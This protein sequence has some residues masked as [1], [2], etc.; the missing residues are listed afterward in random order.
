MLFIFS[1]KLTCLTMNTPDTNPPESGSSALPRPQTEEATAKARIL[2]EFERQASTSGPKGVSMAEL[3]RSLG[4]ST[5]TLYRHFSNKVEL[6]TALMES[7]EQTWSRRQ[8]DNIKHARPP[9][10]RIRDSALRWMEHTSQFS[11]LFWLQIEKDFPEAHRLYQEGHTN[12]LERARQ[13][14]TPYIRDDLEPTLALAGLMALI[15]QASDNTL[16][17]HLNI[18]R[19][20]AVTQSVHL[21][22]SGALK[23]PPSNKD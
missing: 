7:W 20:D 6:V 22:A 16:C 23:T 10:E 14:L 1:D 21:W 8:Q 13:N 11:P 18:T 9:Q 17:D 19:R 15:T 12:F 2:A 3:A 4:I 5:K